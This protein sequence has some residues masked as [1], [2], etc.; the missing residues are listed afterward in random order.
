M[1]RQTN[2]QS[3]Y[4]LAEVL[5]ALAIFAIIFLAALTAY[6]RSNRVFKTGVESSNMQQNTRV[7]FDKVAAD[8]RMAGFD[9]DR[10]GIPTGQSVGG[11][12][13]YQQPDEQFEYIAPGAVT[14]RAN[15]DFETENQPC[16]PPTVTNNCDNGREG[17]LESSYFPVVTTANDEIVTYALVPSS[18]ENGPFPAC[19]PNSNCVQFYADVTTPRKSYPD[20]GGVDEEL[21]QIP[22]VDL[23]LNGCNNPPY[24][25]YRFTLSTDPA[26]GDFLNGDNITRTPLASNIRSMTLKYY[27]DAQGTVPLMDLTNTNDVSTGATIL[28]NGQFKVATPDALV[29]EREIRAKIN[30]VRLTLIGMNENR[31]QA[32]TDT[33]EAA[34]LNGSSPGLTGGPNYIDQF[35]KYRL[36]TLVSPRNIQKRGMREQDT[37]PP[38]PPTI[39]SICTGACAGVYMT[40]AAPPVN[41]TYGA[42]DQ[43]KVIYDLASSNGYNCETTTFTDTQTFVFGT[44]PACQIIP[45][46]LYKFAVVALNSYGTGT[47][48]PLNATP[49][50]A[51]Q[52]D[53]P[54]LVM[55]TTGATAQNGK[56][57]LTWTRPQT[58]ASGA[59]SCGP[60][61]PNAAETQGY[62]VERQVAPSGPWVQLPQPNGLSGNSVTTSSPY[63]TVTWTDASAVNCVTYNYRVTTVESCYWNT[64]YNNPSTSVA[65]EVGSGMCGQMGISVP[66]N[67]MSG[68][69]SSTIAPN[70]PAD[71]TIDSVNTICTGSLCN[72]LMSWPRVSTDTA[73]NPITIDAYVVQRQQISPTTTTWGDRGTVTGGALTYTDMNVDTSNGAVYYYRILALSEC[74]TPSGT[75]SAPS[76]QRPYPCTFPA[77]VLGTPLVS[78]LAAFDG[79]GSASNPFKIPSGT[80]ADANINVIDTSQIARVVGRDYNA[81]GSL[82][83]Q[84]TLTAPTGT[85]PNTYTFTWALGTN[86]TEQFNVA[87]VDAGV[88]CVDQSFAYYEDE[89]QNCCLTPS[90]FDPTVVSFS[91]G[92]QYVDYVLKNVCSVPLTITGM[93]LTW[94]SANTSGGTHLDSVIFPVSSGG[95]SS[96]FGTPLLSTNCSAYTFS[97]A[98]PNAGTATPVPGAAGPGTLPSGILTVP[99]GCTNCVSGVNLGSGGTGYSLTPTITFTGGGGTGA[100]ATAVVTSGVITGI[101]VTDPG[102]NYTSAPTATITDTTGTGASVSSVTVNPKCFGCIASVT[103]AGGAS[104]SG[105]TSAPSVSFVGGGGSGATATATISG[106][107]VTGVNVTN[108][109]SGYTSA[110]SVNF[111]GGGGSGATATAN[112][113]ALY[114]IRVHF[115]KSLNNPTPPVTALSI[116]YTEPNGQSAN[117]CAI[118]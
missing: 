29:P 51:T 114:K 69:A 49:I 60:S 22:G 91:T 9:F 100:Q 18:N 113:N 95:C 61:V 28:G 93:S 36:E 105:Y 17:A 31:D 111:S 19:D 84:S 66:S 89:P 65:C 82:L 46:Q 8:L 4:T 55:T 47:S 52:P 81:G 38:G 73:G 79:N 112:I 35:R 58:I 106:G 24:T 87:V 76:P 101:L 7:A 85:A 71:L 88:G 96:T 109:G 3:G 40:W 11:T 1:N 43:Y 15:F 116:N 13:V 67:V 34:G 108:P 27:Q 37:F 62:I 70:P 92:T 20:T 103:V 110:P 53:A 64:A 32:Y 90:T 42:P 16:N 83:W 50:N 21:V 39:T 14:V 12:N 97:G 68:A 2:R 75:R 41:A 72:V 23:C 77:G 45:G 54:K 56:V 33:A 86:A 102:S 80:S 74:P 44:T 94:S 26:A 63:D 48:A 117:A 25:L 57:T 6:D 5:V 98:G 115:T 104:G 78:S 118:K 107:K 59:Y 10:D 30:S 99:P